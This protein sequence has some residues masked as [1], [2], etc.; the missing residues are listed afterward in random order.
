VTA[1]LRRRDLET[2][3]AVT[4]DDDSLFRGAEITLSTHS[5]DVRSYAE[6]FARAIG[7]SS[8]LVDDLA[9][10]GWFHDIGKA[11]PRFQRWLVGG[12]EVRAA[13]LEAPLAKSAL[14]PGNRAERQLAQRRAGYPKGSRHELLSLDMIARH[15]DILARA[16]DCE[17]VLHLVASH[18]GWCRPF[19]PPIDHPEEIVVTLNHGDTTLQGNTR[20]RAAQLDSGTAERFWNLTTRYGWWGLAWLEAA[21]RLADHRA[22][23]DRA[24]AGE[25]GAL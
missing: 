22:S 3:D 21:L 24:Y 25:E 11:D 14:P 6:R 9:L 7:F 19:A 10:A 18:H 5:H 4:E 17:L 12:S 23:E 13:L 2:E 8:E 16:H 15:T 1:P 20:H